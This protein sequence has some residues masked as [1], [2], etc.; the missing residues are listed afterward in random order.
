MHKRVVRE[1][2]KEAQLYL[3]HLGEA[4]SP[5]DDAYRAAGTSLGSYT[6]SGI[7]IG[8]DSNPDLDNKT[9][10]YGG[11]NT[12]TTVLDDVKLVRNELH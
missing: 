7:A 3:H 5:Y 9:T 12:V 8:K 2:A 6:I 4:R 11:V 10:I 1:A